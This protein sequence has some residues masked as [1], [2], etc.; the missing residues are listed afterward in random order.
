MFPSQ[1]VTDIMNMNQLN[2]SKEDD[3]KKPPACIWSKFR[4]Y[5]IE[6]LILHSKMG[7]RYEWSAT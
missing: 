3:I 1:N 5:V 6:K 4:L 2:D 7:E